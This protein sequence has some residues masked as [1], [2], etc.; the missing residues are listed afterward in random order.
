MTKITTLYFRDY[1]FLYKE[2]P[3]R[4]LKMCVSR[5]V[6]RQKQESVGVSPEM[7]LS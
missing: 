5:Q 4:L 1:C 3:K 7:V 6:C 2:G